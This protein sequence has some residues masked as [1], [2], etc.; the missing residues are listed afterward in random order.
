[1]GFNGPVWLTVSI[2]L[3]SGWQHCHEMGK[4]WGEAERKKLSQIH[5]SQELYE[6]LGE[7]VKMQIRSCE[8]E[9]ETLRF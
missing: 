4:S 2:I 9:P 1:M 7:F 3:G 5:P 6:L 8:V